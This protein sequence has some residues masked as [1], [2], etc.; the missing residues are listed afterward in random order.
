MIYYV[1]TTYLIWTAPASTLTRPDLT[2]SINSNLGGRGVGGCGGG[3]LVGY[4]ML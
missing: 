2:P 3:K 1:Y 4:L